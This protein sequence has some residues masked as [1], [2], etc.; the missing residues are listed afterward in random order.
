MLLQGL[1]GDPER[2]ILDFLFITLLSGSDYTPRLGG[3][4]YRRV[5]FH[6][7]AFKADPANRDAY[8]LNPTSA[9]RATAGSSPVESILNQGDLSRYMSDISINLQ[10]LD[11]ILQGSNLTSVDKTSLQIQHKTKLRDVNISHSDWKGNWNALRQAFCANLKIES[12]TTSATS[13]GLGCSCTIYWT[14]PTTNEKYIAGE[15][16]GINARTA[17][18]F[19]ALSACMPSSTVMSHYIALQ[20][21][22][23]DFLRLSE[24]IIS[25]V[26]SLDSSFWQEK[27]RIKAPPADYDIPHDGHSSL[28]HS[29]HAPS[30]PSPSSNSAT[31]T[32]LRNSPNLA[33]PTENSLPNERL[34]KETSMEL[35][36]SHQKT[37][38]HVFSVDLSPKSKINALTKDSKVLVDHDPACEELLKGVIW[39]ILTFSAEIPNGTQFYPYTRTPTVHALQ[40]YL[41]RAY[42]HGSDLNFALTAP[43]TASGDAHPT[44][45]FSPSLT[46]PARHYS[47]DAIPPVQWFASVTGRQSGSTAVLGNAAKRM[48]QSIPLL[49]RPVMPCFVQEEI[50]SSTPR[51]S[52]K[53][54][55]P[56]QVAD[57]MELK[58]ETKRFEALLRS[59]VEPRDVWNSIKNYLS[60]RTTKATQAE[61]DQPKSLEELEP[62]FFQV[63]PSLLFFSHAPLRTTTAEE[64]ADYQDFQARNAKL[65]GSWSGHQ[66]DLSEISNRTSES[67]KTWTGAHFPK[68]ACFEE[69]PV[70]RDA[71]GAVPAEA[72]TD[73]MRLNSLARQRYRPFTRQK[74]NFAKRYY[75]TWHSSPSYSGWKTKTCINKSVARSASKPPTAESCAFKRLLSL[76]IRIK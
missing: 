45:P 64:R 67:I 37:S 14:D 32:L 60:T 3:Y 65:I 21:A 49:E 39:T 62:G 15:G 30:E 38:P 47:L 72:N 23:E 4:D 29:P 35:G 6:W 68:L 41:A 56:R 63:Q 34:E 44:I 17:E 18:Y 27:P 54:P 55:R 22:S 73:T 59:G 36:T 50:T 31:A 9:Q 76:M 69:E 20:I 10:T 48:L 66:L 42:Q 51:E 46:I 70:F 7:K 52:S 58:N 28:S 40:S 11:L 75:S 13:Q 24:A 57:K 43:S 71:M 25:V 5:Y 16:R 2:I 74:T 26:D 1:A 33:T 61:Q 8:I 19:A 53:T 12:V